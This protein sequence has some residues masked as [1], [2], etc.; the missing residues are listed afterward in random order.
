MPIV[1]LNIVNVWSKEEKMQISNAIHKALVISLKIPDGDY[2]HRIIEYN[3]E[4]WQL[5]PG[6]SD[7]YILIECALFPGR[8][9]ETKK[10][11]FKE[12]IEKLKA[13]NISPMDIMIIINEQPMENWGIRGGIPADEVELGYSLE[14]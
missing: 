5:P 9:K 12:I 2:N 1:K 14:V 13:F 3:K 4:T 8:S 10:K 7:K 11:L 6:K